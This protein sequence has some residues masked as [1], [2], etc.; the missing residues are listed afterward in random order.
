MDRE[1]INIVD[2]MHDKDLF[3]PLFKNLESWWAWEV[4]LKSLFGLEM[5][6]PERKLYQNC[7]GRKKVFKGGF[8]E[9]YAICGR[10]GGKSFVAALSAVYM[11]LFSGLE[12]QL[13]TGETGYIFCIAT[14]K[15]QARI[16]L[17]YIKGFLELFPDMLDGEPLT[18]EIRLKNK[19]NIEVRPANFRAGR[20]ATTI[21]IIL[22]ELAFYRDENSANP[23]E[24]L[25]NSLLPGLHKDGL[26]LGLSTPYAKFGY[27]YEMYRNYFGN[28]DSDIMVWKGETQLMNS[29]Y[30]IKT[31]RRLIKRDPTKMTAEF[32]AEF[33]EDIEQF[34]GEDLVDAA[35]E[36]FI[37]KMPTRGI[38]YKAFCDP[39]GGRQDSM[40]LGIAHS[41]NDI[42][43]VDRVEEIRPPFVPD[44]IVKNFCEIIKHYNCW[45]IVG[46]QYAGEWV[47]SSF[48]K[49]GIQYVPSKLNKSEIYLNAQPLFS[50]SKITLPDNERL[51]TQLI[52]LERRPRS[53]GKDLV[54]HP[55]KMSDDIA[56]SA[57][58]AAVS[59]Q[60][61][62]CYRP[63][64]EELLGRRA[65]VS[66]RSNFRAK[67]KLK[68]AEI[69]EKEEIRDMIQQTRKDFD[70]EQKK[71]KE[72]E[73]SYEEFFQRSA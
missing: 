42:I 28:D 30:S 9:C 5:S 18:W 3:R 62:I 69:L 57:C 37:F 12:K 43:H 14:D 21:C 6:K 24:E 27:L 64:E 40:T 68:P 29:E 10:R 48:K 4:F 50:A 31:I 71:K 17:D 34:L 13:G 55:K 58:G 52:T 19:I 38:T 8:K 22:D 60:Q 25:V 20:G 33:R 16:V 59:V 65:V 56:N 7:T 66:G 39:S 23:A 73:I 67:R 72:N 26:L 61:E 54:D 2:A 32:M 45:Q 47:S 15:R 44:E 35:I 36:K 51:K 11:A 53:G 1:N 41:E 63:S 70:K 46:D 49:H